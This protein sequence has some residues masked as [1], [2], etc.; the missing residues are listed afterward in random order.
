MAREVDS[1]EN[2]AAPRAPHASPV[3][4]GRFATAV[5]SPAPL[6]LAQRARKV[7][8]TLS[9]P[10]ALTPQEEPRGRLVSS[11]GARI[12]AFHAMR[13]THTRSA[14]QHLLST[15]GFTLAPAAFILPASLCLSGRVQTLG[16]ENRKWLPHH[17]NHRNSTQCAEPAPPQLNVVSRDVAERPLLPFGVSGTQMAPHHL[18]VGVQARIQATYTAT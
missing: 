10:H 12:A 8:G 18:Q 16:S 7:T 5:G 9:K 6:P 15:V 17:A 3:S 1:L 11:V 13:A 2:A 14:Q 4:S